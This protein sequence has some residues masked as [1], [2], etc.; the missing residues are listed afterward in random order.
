MGLKVTLILIFYFFVGFFQLKADTYPGVLFE[1]SIL[2]GNYSESNASFEGNSWIRHAAGQIPVTDSI[3]FTPGNALL[4]NYV[5]ASGGFWHAAIKFGQGRAYSTNKS[6]KLSFK[7]FVQGN[8]LVS[9]LPMLRIIRDSS[10]S[11]PL[12]LAKYI[13]SYQ[14]NM[15]FSVDIPVNELQDSLGEEPITAVVFSQGS[16]DGK[17]HAIFIDQIEF[18]TST[19]P[20]SALTGQAVLSS[21]NAFERHVDLSW[22]L[23]L[24]PSIRYIK[25]YRSEDQKNFQPVA[26]RP[27]YYRKYTDIV[28][29]TGKSY[30]YKIAWVDFQYR[31]SPFSE[32]KKAET[33]VITDEELLDAIEKA[34][35]NYFV[36]RVEINSAMQRTSNS[37][38]NAT[39]SVKNTGAGI[40]A[41]IAGAERNSISR[42]ALLMRLNKMTD[43]LSK[44]DR[45][46]GA[47]PKYINGRTGKI[48]PDTSGRIEG[49]LESTAFLMQGLLCARQYFNKD[50]R[51]EA[52]L[53]EH[54]TLLWESVNWSDFTVTTN[55]L[56]LYNTWSPASEWAFSHPMGGYNTSFIS[57][58]LAIASPKH[59]ISP[60][61]YAQAYARPLIPL[62]T[63]W[64]SFTLKEI[65]EKN[66]QKLPFTTKEKQL[67]KENQSIS[68]EEKMWLTT[69]LLKQQ[70]LLKKDSL[71]YDTV[72]FDSIS[73]KSKNF[74]R[75]QYVNDSVYFG[76][77]LKVGSVLQ[78]LTEAMSLYMAFD[79]R[80]KQDAFCNYFLNMTNLTKIHYRKDV[81]SVFLPVQVSQDI[82][83]YADDIAAK[84]VIHPAAAVAAY[85]YLP[86]AALKV[87]GKYYRQFGYFL[88]AEY[89]FRRAFNLNKNWV[90]D[91]Y[92]GLDQ[93]LVAV[94]IENARTGLIWKL[95]MQDPDISKASEK[96]F[97]E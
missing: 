34:H 16:T 77:K 89:G 2:P 51:A 60:I 23:P 72:I 4:L 3:F 86:T 26:V 53:R 11:K 36:E 79:P 63:V 92:D 28:P 24:T 6:E 56:Y 84:G 35:I 69:K 82:W 17:E 48:V 9:E 31:E 15:W 68:E 43:F 61:S 64:N 54:I 97:A 66:N 80:K 55:G 65:A 57:Y 44:A 46:N 38:K 5:S 94:N 62:D 8:T 47:W 73:G 78:P 71:L 93:A 32:V 20:E 29:I 27:I 58:F 7:L 39:V 45:F 40:L 12:F 33:K 90:E 81:S 67:L 30:Y 96:L 88:F 91:D 70:S 83:G 25:I 1:N 59:A 13:D 76:V 19:P 95:F 74:L 75:K 50:D 14:Q 52:D 85:P 10:L 42:E 37:Q 22:Q 49:D 21:V 87:M 18:V 41:L